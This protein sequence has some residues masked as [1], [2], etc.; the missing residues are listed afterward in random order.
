MDLTLINQA[1]RVLT[2]CGARPVVRDNAVAV[3]I[4]KKFLMP[5]VLQPNTAV[6][7]I[8]EITG[9]TIWS[10]RAISSDGLSRSGSI[11]LGVRVQIQL[12]S[13]RFLFGGNGIDVG[14][15][16]GIGS[17][18]YLVQPQEDCE[19]GSTIQVT[20]SDYLGL[21][22]NAVVLNMVFEGSYMFFLRGGQLVKPGAGANAIPRYQ[23][24]PNQNI[25]A[26][27]W[28]GGY[29]PATPQGY[30]DS[31]FTHSSDPL[32]FG[33]GGQVTQTLKIPIDPPYDFICRRL[34]FDVTAD[35]TVTNGIFL[36]RVR[37]GTG[38][39]LND[40]F[41][42]IARY[43]NGLEWPKGW[44]V[45]GGD[46]IFVDLAMA[47]AVGAGNMYFQAHFEGARRRKAA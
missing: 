42:D 8:K 34:L 40:Q 38:Y 33:L 12:P 18:R 3:P 7:F 24:T 43:L 39:A 28:M 26:P 36:A 22:D 44:L 19:P 2:A 45:R 25:L 6:N 14:L 15:W 4:Q 37:S 35:D 10:M 23:R 11:P 31:V 47:D 41:I 9:D 30:E 20:L 46:A 16:S 27:P 1:H 5:M 17:Q 29:G 32:V 13:G 21:L